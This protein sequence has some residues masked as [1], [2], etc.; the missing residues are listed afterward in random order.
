MSLQLVVNLVSYHYAVLEREM[1]IIEG[2]RL[3]QDFYGEE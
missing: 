3:F 2:I 1:M